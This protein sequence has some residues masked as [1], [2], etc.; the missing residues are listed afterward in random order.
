[1]VVAGLVLLSAVAV[2]APFADL[3][4]CVDMCVSCTH[5]AEQL[6]LMQ[7]RGVRG[8]AE[9]AHELSSHFKLEGRID[10]PRTLFWGY[11]AA[12]NGSIHAAASLETYRQHLNYGVPEFLKDLSSIK[13]DTVERETGV[14]DYVKY[15]ISLL[16]GDEV[17]E[18]NLSNALVRAGIVLPRNIYLQKMRGKA[19]RSILPFRCICITMPAPSDAPDTSSAEY[20]IRVPEPNCSEC[21]TTNA[22]NCTCFCCG[23]DVKCWQEVLRS[24]LCLDDEDKEAA[25]VLA[26]YPDGSEYSNYD[27]CIKHVEKLLVDA[28]RRLGFPICISKYVD[29][30]GKEHVM[31][32]D[33]KDYV[34]VL[35]RLISADGGLKKTR[36]LQ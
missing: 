2:K 13:F 14:E 35:T 8:D 22:V 23:V 29:R 24:E 30:S 16:N 26:A 19:T 11:I 1:M 27:I 31:P 7:E 20:W 18:N 21:N 32:C 6:R 12:V 5:S 9:C 25:V 17:S 4:S 15:L 28:N 10:R 34:R 3:P 36:L 33:G